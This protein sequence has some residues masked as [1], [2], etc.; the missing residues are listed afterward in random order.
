[1]KQSTSLNLVLLTLRHPFEDT[2]FTTTNGQWASFLFNK[3]RD[4]HYVSTVLSCSTEI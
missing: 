2:S 3:G 1:M 4:N